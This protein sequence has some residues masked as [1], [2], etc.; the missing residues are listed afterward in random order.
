MFKVTVSCLND[1][2][3]VTYTKTSGVVTTDFEKDG[4]S[5]LWFIY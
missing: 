3:Q 5:L 1:L 4:V 2:G